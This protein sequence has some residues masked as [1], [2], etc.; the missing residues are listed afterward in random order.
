[1]APL[2]VWFLFVTPSVVLEFGGQRA[3]RI[4]SN[5]A[6]VFVT[7]SL[8]WFADYLRRGLAGRPGPKLPRWGRILHRWLHS[9]L[10][11][12]LFGVALTG[13]LLGL[14]SAVV[15]KA[16]GWL[17]FAPPLDLERANEAIG[18]VHIA[19]F[20]MLAAVVV[21]HAGFHFWRHLRLRDNALRIMA[22]RALHRWL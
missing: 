5:I 15:R 13:F 11:W 20:Y 22:P 12:G 14:T 3:F 7:L 4:H 16:G 2:I 21:I 17:P 19:E 6:L 8:L 9:L 18:R 1:M 10:I